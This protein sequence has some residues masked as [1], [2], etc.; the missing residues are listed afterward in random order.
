MTDVFLLC[1][2]FALGAGDG[3]NSVAMQTG[4]RVRCRTAEV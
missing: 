1:L 2:P 4:W 3:V